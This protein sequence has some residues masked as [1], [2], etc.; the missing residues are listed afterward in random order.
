MMF[1]SKQLTST[2]PLVEGFSPVNI[3]ATTEAKH[4]RLGQYLHSVTLY[5]LHLLGVSFLLSFWMW[6]WF[7]VC[8]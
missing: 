7:V 1:T 8:G 2:L 5:L 6:L 4:L 3:S